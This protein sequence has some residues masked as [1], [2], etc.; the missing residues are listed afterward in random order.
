MFLRSIYT[1]SERFNRKRW[2]RIFTPISEVTPCFGDA[3]LN[4][5]SSPLLHSNIELESKISLHSAA[6]GDDIS[7][8]NDAVFINNHTIHSNSADLYSQNSF[9]SLSLS[10]SPICGT[11]NMTE[12]NLPRRKPSVF[13]R[14]YDVKQFLV[15]AHHV[16]SSTPAVNYATTSYRTNNMDCSDSSDSF[17]ESNLQTSIEEES[18]NCFGTSPAAG[19]DAAVILAPPKLNIPLADE[20]KEFQPQNNTTTENLNSSNKGELLF[21]I[22]RYY[23]INCDG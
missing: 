1:C 21:Y 17:K 11:P 4:S 7:P 3:P 13:E 6:N 8:V 14:T 2:G 20:A 16:V 23:I 22:T 15:Q 9:T 18:L 5:N 10:L 12:R 19:N